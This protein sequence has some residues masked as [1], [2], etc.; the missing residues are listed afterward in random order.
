MPILKRD[1]GIQFA[2][3]AYRELLEPRKTSLLRNEVRMLAQN[4]G[5]YV[6][7]FTQPSGQ[8]E[9]VFSRDPGFL[10]GEAIW[11]H[12]SKP[13]DLI[14]CEALPE[15]HFAIV[16]VVRGGSVYL[17][18]K[19]PYSNI[20]DEFASL[21]TGA[22]RYDIYVYGDVPVSP[23]KERGKFSFDA[24]QVK[25]FTRLEQS[26]FKNLVV[27][28]NL[29]LQP[30]EFALRAQ[31]IGKKFPITWLVSIIIFFALVGWLHHYLSVPKVAPP[32]SATTQQQV[33]PFAGY[34]TALSTPA[35]EK[36]IAELASDITT[37]YMMPGWETTGVTFAG[38]AYT[39]RVISIGGPIAA[40]NE[41]A[42]SHNM[43][44]SIDSQGATLTMTSNLQNRDLPTTIYPLR[45]VLYTVIDR[46]DQVLAIPSVTL[47]TQTFTPG[48][49]AAPITVQFSD[50]SPSVLT[51]IGRQVADLPIQLNTAQ[52]TISHGLLSGSLQLTILGNEHNET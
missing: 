8:I 16:V 39:I 43:N 35:P 26:V 9:A 6:R 34:K 49:Q 12:F 25:S 46:I 2:I 47:G 37:T 5:E 50:I 45:Q 52:I 41:W 13:S 4:H 44:M 42:R 51:L 10:L 30:L 19:I 31:K 1:D 17:D 11:Q 24:T 23:K 38:S 7:L 28:E 48:Y 3:H 33:D 29:Q 32:P 27:D 36:Q 15:G 22:N 21:V 18:T 20:P 40:L 14:Y